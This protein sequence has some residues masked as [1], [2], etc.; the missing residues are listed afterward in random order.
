MP[1]GPRRGPQG[2]H[3]VEQPGQR[4]LLIATALGALSSPGDP[5]F[6]IVLTPAEE[7]ILTV[8]PGSGRREHRDRIRARTALAADPDE[9]VEHVP[10]TVTVPGGA[11]Q[12]TAAIITTRT[13]GDTSVTLT[14]A[15]GSA[16]ASKEIFLRR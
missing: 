5:P 8:R 7:T 10:A 1:P 6:V 11:E 13:R 3:R 9:V 16:S 15:Y 12:V 2:G 4:H 14:A